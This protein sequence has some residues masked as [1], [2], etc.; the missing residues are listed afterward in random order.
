MPLRQLKPGEE[1]EAISGSVIEGTSLGT[2]DLVSI[3]LRLLVRKA[4]PSDLGQYAQSM[5][6]PEDN[7]PRRSARIGGILWRPGSASS[8]PRLCRRGATA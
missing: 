8:E 2:E 3:V 7:A 6:D 4:R 5:E 1:A